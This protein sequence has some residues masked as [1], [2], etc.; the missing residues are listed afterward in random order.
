MK[1]K[2]VS[3]KKGSANE[4]LALIQELSDIISIVYK[5]QG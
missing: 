1:K 5:T 4:D 3:L 2:A